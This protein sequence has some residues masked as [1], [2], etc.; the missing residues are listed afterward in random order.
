MRQKHYSSSIIYSI[1]LKDNDTL[2]T[3]ELFLI[4]PSI[5]IKLLLL[6]SILLKI[7]DNS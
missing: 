1:R 3:N 6:L 2:S 4:N 7:F 5:K